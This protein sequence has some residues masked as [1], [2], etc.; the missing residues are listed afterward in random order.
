M[1]ELNAF[2]TATSITETIPTNYAL[3][4]ATCVD[5]G[6]TPIGTTLVGG[7]LTI[8]A[9]AVVG[10]ANLTCTFVN[11]R[12]SAQVRVDKRWLGAVGNN[13]VTIT[14][15]GGTNNPSLV[16]VANTADRGRR[17]HRRHRVR[18]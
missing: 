15:T 2:N 5:G 8:A 6:G 14:S 16:A 11:T 10:G 13:A 7:T 9:G 17:R 4:S 3:T 18:R 12:K 1:F